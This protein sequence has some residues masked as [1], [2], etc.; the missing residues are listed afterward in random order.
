MRPNRCELTRLFA[1]GATAERRHRV[2]AD[3]PVLP[4]LVEAV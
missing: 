2:G 1:A 4:C 3:Y